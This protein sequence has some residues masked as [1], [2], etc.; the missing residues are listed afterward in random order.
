MTTLDLLVFVVAILLALF[1]VGV[2]L[3]WMFF[4]AR[5]KR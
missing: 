4:R 1:A 2:I 3:F 5:K